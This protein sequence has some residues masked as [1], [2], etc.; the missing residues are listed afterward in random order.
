MQLS[1]QS[2]LIVMLF[3]HISSFDM[4]PA[5][6]KPS[7]YSVSEETPLTTV[8]KQTT[9]NYDKPS[10]VMKSLN[11]K[12]NLSLNGGSTFNP[13]V[14]ETQEITAKAALS[15]LDESLQGNTSTD[16]N[17]VENPRVHNYSEHI[18]DGICNDQNNHTTEVY[19][20]LPLSWYL[21]VT[22]TP[23]TLSLAVPLNLGIIWY[24]QLI[25]DNRRTLINKMTS[26]LSC[27]SLLWDLIVPPVISLRMILGQLSETI[28]KAH[29]SLIQFVIIMS[30]LASD[31]V[32]ILQY[33]YLCHFR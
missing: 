8:V 27:Y 14:K 9:I 7:F 29:I 3:K 12:R 18:Q 20:R 31:E 24:E 23:V 10:Q 28:C 22:P 25:N 19:A 13:A 6:Q 26:V 16:L 2:Y 30:L 32:L 1:F 21:A 17:S 15:E 33:L 4:K 5:I 11:Q